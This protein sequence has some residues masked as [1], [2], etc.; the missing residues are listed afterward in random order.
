MEPACPR[1][2]LDFE[3]NPGAF[4]GGVGL[5]TVITFVAVAVAI[6]FAFWWT[7]SDRTV[8]SVL[9]GP[10]LLALVLP[11]AFFPFSKT[12]WLAVELIATPPDDVESGAADP[13]E[14]KGA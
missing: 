3:R 13:T 7:D 1:C 5:N 10:M 11:L 12:L 14:T 4:I 8:L 9:L 6:G 2:G